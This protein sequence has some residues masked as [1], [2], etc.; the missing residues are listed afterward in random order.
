MSTSDTA[1][2]VCR[3]CGTGTPRHLAA[4]GS[5]P[6]SSWFRRPE[7][8]PAP[9]FP[10]AM[11]RCPRCGSVQLTEPVPLAALEPVP[12]WLRFSEP[13]GHLPAVVDALPA[14]GLSGTPRV[15]GLGPDD[16][17]LLAAIAGRGGQTRQIDWLTEG[18]TSATP[19]P[20]AIHAH[21]TA[22]TA[23]ALRERH[24][25]STLILARYL[26]EH[27]P[28]VGTFLD[29]LAVL[30][31]PGGAVLFEVPDC[32]QAFAT[33]DYTTL[34]EE[35]VFY[36]T[37]GALQRALAARGWRVLSARSY[38]NPLHNAL[39]VVAAPGGATAAGAPPAE[40]L[41]L[42]DGFAAAYDA[43]RERAAAWC[44]RQARERGPLALFGAGHVGLTFLVA[45]GV[46]HHLS[47]VIDD[48]PAKQDL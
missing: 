32:S 22:A 15:L 16:G 44:E 41:A 28:D 9:R 48:S 38:D 1:V 18:G 23:R 36:F 21:L 42:G 24:G 17:P 10:L 19:R 14:G 34:W 47:G 20:A 39:V 29:A 8:P 25:G 11:S 37:P 12:S 2:P 4:F 6:I 46:A 3:A 45:M 40:E 33:H 31:D 13:G 35:H 5:H 26:L 30:L 27:A 7:D 43:T